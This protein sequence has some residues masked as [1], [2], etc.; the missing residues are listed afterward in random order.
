[1]TGAINSRAL[2]NQWLFSTFMRHRLTTQSIAVQIELQ[3]L[4]VFASE[5][6]KKSVIQHSFTRGG[7]V[8][9]K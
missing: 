6:K 5:N 9:L 7:L 2:R 8:E 4:T 3:I 1:M